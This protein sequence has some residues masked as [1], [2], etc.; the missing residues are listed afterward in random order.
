MFSDRLIN[1]E[2]RNWFN[3]LLQNML[4]ETFKCDI[5]NIIGKK[6]LFYGDFCDTGGDYERII[7]I[8]K[9]I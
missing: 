5:S 3:R 1:D 6:P 7:D 8:E 9:V 2:D 4:N